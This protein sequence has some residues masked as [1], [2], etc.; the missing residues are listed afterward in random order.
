MAV[1]VSGAL[2]IALG[3]FLEGATFDAISQLAW[4][5]LPDRGHRELFAMGWNG[6]GKGALA[7]HRHSRA[8]DRLFADEPAA[9]PEQ[10]FRQD[11]EWFSF[12]T[13]ASAASEALIFSSYV[14]A[15]AYDENPIT[16]SNLRN[17]LGG[18]LDAIEGVRQTELLGAFVRAARE[19]S[20]GESLIAFRDVFLHRGR[21]GRNH[22]VGG[23]HDGR[24]T[25]ARNP[26]G[27]PSAWQ[28]DRYLE[29]SGLEV[30]GDWLRTYATW[31][32]PL[33][34]DALDSLP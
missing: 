31:S 3:R 24:I 6:L 2:G 19:D 28:P 8:F 14:L 29:A 13:N 34:R 5:K 22:W 27:I 10:R 26:K 4:Q 32:M 20:E 33:L 11:D 1:H 18:M 17:R 12:V 15:R 25:V 7:A 23:A 9:S 30:W 16:E 21:L